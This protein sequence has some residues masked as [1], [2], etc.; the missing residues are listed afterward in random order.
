MLCAPF[1]GDALYSMSHYSVWEH[2]K[3]HCQEGQK[4]GSSNKISIK[5]TSSTS[6]ENHITKAET[7]RWEGVQSGHRKEPNR[8][9]V[10]NTAVF[11][12]T[13]SQ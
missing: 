9:E 6:A 3:I 7:R 12:G 13:D 8:S 4:E 11:G 10:V 2:L 5:T 1:P